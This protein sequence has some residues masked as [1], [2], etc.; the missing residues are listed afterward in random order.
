MKKLLALLLTLSL[1]LPAAMPALA[2]TAPEDFIGMWN[3]IR[4]PED[5]TD[6]YE[7]IVFYPD[8]LCIDVNGF[9][10]L[11]MY[12]P[13]EYEW[14][15]SGG[16]ILVGGESEFT[17][18]NGR[19]ESYGNMIY[20]K[21]EWMADSGTII[22]VDD[23]QN[24]QGEWESYAVGFDFRGAYRVCPAEAMGDKWDLTFYAPGEG[25]QLRK[26]EMMS[27]M[28]LP[29]LNFNFSE[30][31]IEDGGIRLCQKG[32]TGGFLFTA[33]ENGWL[34]MGVT[35]AENDLGIKHY[36]LF[37]RQ[38]EAQEAVTAQTAQTAESSAAPAAEANYVPLTET[39]W[40]GRWDLTA[41]G[42]DISIGDSTQQYK[43]EPGIGVKNSQV[44]FDP[45]G[46]GVISL[47]TQDDDHN[48]LYL[49]KD[50]WAE[51]NVI[52]TSQTD[53]IY[54]PETGELTFS[55]GPYTLYHQKSEWPPKLGREVEISS[56]EDYYGVWE[57]C[58]IDGS[59][60]NYQGLIG[61]DLGRVKLYFEFNKN[62]GEEVTITR[63]NGGTSYSGEG[64][65]DIKVKDGKLQI[66]HYVSGSVY[67][68][69][70]TAYENGWISMTFSESDGTK[71]MM[72]FE[73]ND[74]ALDNYRPSFDNEADDAG[75]PQQTDP[76]SAPAAASGRKVRVNEGSNPNVRSQP[77]TDGQKVGTARSGKTYELLDE[78]NGWYKIRLEDGTEGWI[79]GGMAQIVKN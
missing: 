24:Y 16:R 15:F 67:Y 28:L 8:G 75:A 48:S 18:N 4:D 77:G 76:T 27:G 46:N 54:L 51:E 9:T 64:L 55:Y 6:F 47:M 63:E 22:A 44:Y 21:Q 32:E 41:V 71:Y 19:L 78:R 42:M 68:A 40:H 72:Y 39:E 45:T 35:A 65:S 61:G 60:V 50:C 43:T 13:K 52:H 73:R 30:A 74:H 29:L 79:S 23:L 12:L 57:Q 33:Y 34:A 14:T 17:L 70:A 59:I 26:F 20:Q 11:N 49:A 62:G 1:L 58:A 38:K 2:E 37:F 56:A 31:R 25:A 36:E 5:T 53:F 3:C 66:G 7:T 10:S 69:V